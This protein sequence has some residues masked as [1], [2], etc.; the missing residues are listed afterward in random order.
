MLK[1]SPFKLPPLELLQLDSMPL[2][3]KAQSIANQWLNEI[4]IN[5]YLQFVLGVL[6]NNNISPDALYIQ[7]EEDRLYKLLFAIKEQDFLKPN[8]LTIYE[9]LFLEKKLNKQHRQAVCYASFMPYSTTI[10]ESALA[11]DEFWLKYN[12]MACR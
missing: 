12:F 10:N 2:N 11:A 8:M 7:Q 1:N 6:H 5:E 4:Q 9:D 3:P